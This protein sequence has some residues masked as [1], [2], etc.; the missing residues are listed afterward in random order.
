MSRSLVL[1]N[2]KLFHAHESGFVQ[3][4]GV[5]LSKFWQGNILG[6]DIVA[7]DAWIGTPKNTSCAIHV[8]KQFGETAEHL[9]RK[10]L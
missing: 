5:P 7:F 1:E 3:T 9:I 6:F 4:F 2:A 10:L 8:R